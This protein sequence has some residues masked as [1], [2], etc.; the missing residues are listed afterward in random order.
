[1]NYHVAF[2]IW[3]CGFLEIN[4]KALKLRASISGHIS[5]VVLNYMG[6]CSGIKIEDVFGVL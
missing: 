5:V 6:R 4:Y 2:V 1:M 3:I